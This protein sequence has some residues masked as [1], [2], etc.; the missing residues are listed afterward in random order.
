MARQEEDV[1]TAAPGN[2]W[3]R[4][5]K[6]V[7]CVPR[8]SRRSEARFPCPIPWFGVARR[9]WGVGQKQADDDTQEESG[10]LRRDR[11]GGRQSCSN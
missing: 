2:P 6:L 7:V 1:C 8:R 9:D 3:R 10:R 11:N 4:A 5:K